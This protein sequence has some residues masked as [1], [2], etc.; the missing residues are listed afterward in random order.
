MSHMAAQDLSTGRRSGQLR[1]VYSAK[2]N[3]S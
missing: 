3:S 1:G 2:F